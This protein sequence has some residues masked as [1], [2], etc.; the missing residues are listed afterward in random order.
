MGR[1]KQGSERSQGN[2]LPPTPPRDLAEPISELLFAEGGRLGKPPTHSSISLLRA[3]PETRASCLGRSSESVQLRGTGTWDNVASMRASPLPPPAAA[4]PTQGAKG[5]RQGSKCC[6]LHDF[7]ALGKARAP[8]APPS[9]LP[10][11]A[12]QVPAEVRRGRNR[13]P[14]LGSNETISHHVLH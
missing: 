5:T 4:T 10:R 2:T 12:S 6:L 11:T 7:C 3:A 14:A 9:P 1:V 13:I 8:S